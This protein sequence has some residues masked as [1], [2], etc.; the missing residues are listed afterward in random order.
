[1]W[2]Q[3]APVWQAHNIQAGFLHSRERMT[4]VKSG[5]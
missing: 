2:F 5:C 1:M 3:L 4:Q